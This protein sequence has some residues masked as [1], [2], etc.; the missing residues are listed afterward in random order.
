VRESD[1]VARLGG[2]EFAI[3]LM[4]PNDP[5]G[6]T[7]ASQRIVESLARGVEFKGT[8]LTARCSV[9]VA[10]CPADGETQDT[11]YKAADMALY[12]AK[13][14]GGGR[15]CRFDALAADGQ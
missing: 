4:N 8:R 7:M 6:I 2:D 10:I 11:L 12:E 3:L 13:R 9:G 14:S 15:A 1:C 5:E